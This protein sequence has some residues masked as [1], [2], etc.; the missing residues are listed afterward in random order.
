MEGA[1]EEPVPYQSLTATTA[2]INTVAQ[3]HKIMD[4]VHGVWVFF[5][6]IPVVN[7]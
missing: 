4:T 7:E 5:T 3:I 6:P 1:Y 2:T